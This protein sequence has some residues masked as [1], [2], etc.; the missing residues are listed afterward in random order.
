MMFLEIGRY[1]EERVQAEIEPVV[2]VLY[3]NIT[4]N[5]KIGETTIRV[6]DVGGNGR[7]FAGT[8]TAGAHRLVG[9]LIIEVYTPIGE[10]KRVNDTLCDFV[11]AAFRNYSIGTMKFESPGKQRIGEER[12]LF[13]QNVIVPYQYDECFVAN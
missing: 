5:P 3:D 6:T 9:T 2:T 12:D 1:I 10:G 13:H 11:S 4:G 8:A 7:L